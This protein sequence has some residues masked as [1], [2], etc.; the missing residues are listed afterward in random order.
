M[1]AQ[2]S[3][4]FRNNDVI[5]RDY[6]IERWEVA[7]NLSSD[8]LRYFGFCGHDISEFISCGEE[9]PKARRALFWPFVNNNADPRPSDK[10]SMVSPEFG[11]CGI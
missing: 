4:R 7:D 2:R 3:Q 10:L 1:P 11:I 9:L 8:V 5:W 6:L